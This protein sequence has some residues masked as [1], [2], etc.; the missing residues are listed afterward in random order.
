LGIAQVGRHFKNKNP[1]HRTKMENTR[2][3]RRMKPG[4]GL[5]GKA[6]SVAFAVLLSACSSAAA[7]GTMA[8]PAAVT[9]TGTTPAPAVPLAAT[10]AIPLADRPQYQITATLD[11][12]AKVLTV[13]EVAVYP[14]HSEDSISELILQV[15]PARTPGEF[16]LQSASCDRIAD[17]KSP[18][19]ENGLLRIPLNGAVPP[20]GQVTVTLD[21]VLYIPNTPTLPGWSGD[22]IYLGDWYAFFP[23]YQKGSGWL[24]HPPGTAGEHL[25]YTYAD[26]DVELTVHGND[27]Y[28]VAA[29]AVA[30]EEQGV[31]RFD[32][33]GRSFA[34]ALTKQPQTAL[35]SG[36]V[37]AFTETEHAN[38]G[39][40]VAAAAAQA[41]DLY[42][43]IYIDYPHERLTL[44][45]SDLPDGMEYDGLVFLSP[46]IFSATGDNGRDYL[47]A[48][49]VHETAH[50]WW[51]GLVGNDQA[52][53]PWLDEAPA[54]YSEFLYY[55]RVHPED[56]DWWWWTRV[57][58]FQPAGCVDGTIYDFPG[59]REYVNAVYLRGALMMDALRRQMGDENFLAAL[60]ELLTSGARNRITAADF[61]RSL[62]VHSGNGLADIWSEYI[63]SQTVE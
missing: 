8:G 4:I 49:T 34:L 27:G 59:F 2:M 17:G 12:Q 58:R 28:T 43:E 14:N 60:R 18:V 26:F 37:V 23:D 25:S 19:L 11:A 56:L 16:E 6:A 29:S 38:L 48:I 22:R 13:H 61:F 3:D 42:S 9:Q 54:I 40:Y 7:N 31:L 44:L 32:F 36:K 52:L 39:S 51:Y 55:Q 30:T 47:T 57:T 21:Y 62:N 35:D 50:Q 63:C 15:E 41:L 45:E 33:T 5:A 53:N 24:A 20:A 1:C 10:P 46:D